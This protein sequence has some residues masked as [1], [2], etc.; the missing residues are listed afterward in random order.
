MVVP[1][2]WQTHMFKFTK[3]DDKFTN[4]TQLKQEERNREQKVATTTLHSL[5]DQKEITKI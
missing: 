1:T 5:E 2:R 4:K 3:V